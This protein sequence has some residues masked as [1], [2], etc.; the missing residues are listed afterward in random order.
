[1]NID[2]ILIAV[3]ILFSSILIIENMVVQNAIAFVF[4]W[5]K[6]VWVLGLVCLLVGMAM[7]FGIKGV[8]MG[9]KKGFDDEDDF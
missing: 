7:W 3:G 8:L 5:Y 4:I 1:M 6:P 9:D 2:K